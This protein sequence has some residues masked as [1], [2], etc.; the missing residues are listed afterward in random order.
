[1]IGDGLGMFQC[2]AV[3]QIGGNTGCTKGV[4][5]VGRSVSGQYNFH[6]FTQSRRKRDTLASRPATLRGRRYRFED[7]VVKCGNSMGCDKNP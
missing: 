2:A 3:L 4:Q 7:I 6:S 1:M 5:P